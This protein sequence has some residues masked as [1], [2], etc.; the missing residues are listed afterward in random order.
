MPQEPPQPSSP[1]LLPA[2]LGV[3]DVEHLP[4]AQNCP[5]GQAPQGLPQPSSPQLLP[6]QSLM[7]VGVHD[8]PSGAQNASPQQLPQSA[9]HPSAPQARPSQ[10]GVH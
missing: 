3:H 10:L 5:A 8:L 9:P 4:A 2:Q 7:Q 6:A 1:Q